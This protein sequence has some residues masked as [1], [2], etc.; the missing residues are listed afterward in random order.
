MRSRP[1]TSG[2]S[3]EISGSGCD[4][5]IGKRAT[6]ALLRPLAAGLDNDNLD[7][8]IYAARQWPGICGADS[9]GHLL[10]HERGVDNAA[11]YPRAAAAGRERA[12]ASGAVKYTYVPPLSCRGV[13]KP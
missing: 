11:E 9:V 1:P 10:G 4:L 6:G 3:N 2:C 8:H 5:D 7:C 12:P 13:I